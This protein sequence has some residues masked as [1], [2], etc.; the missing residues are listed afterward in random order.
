MLAA[1]LHKKILAVLLVLIV[2]LITSFLFV[3]NQAP[4]E[5]DVDFSN[6]LYP[7]ISKSSQN[8]F[9]VVFFYSSEDKN[10]VETD[11]IAGEVSPSPDMKH[12]VALTP[13]GLVI[14][15]NS[16][17]VELFVTLPTVN[18]VG[19]QAR[20]AD[21]SP[22]SQYVLYYEWIKSAQKDYYVYDLKNNTQLELTEIQDADDVVFLDDTHL[23]IQTRERNGTFSTYVRAYNFV[24]KNYSGESAVLDD[25]YN[26]INPFNNGKKWVFS[27]GN[28]DSSLKPAGSRLTLADFP[29][30]TGVTIDQGRWAEVQ[31]FSYPS[32]DG[33]FIAYYRT[34]RAPD[35]DLLGTWIYSVENKG[36]RHY[37]EAR[38]LGW[39]NDSQFISKEFGG[40]EEV[41]VINIVNDAVE[42]FQSDFY[43][44]S[45][46]NN[47]QK[48][49]LYLQGHTYQ[50]AALR[51]FDA[52]SQRSQ[53]VGFLKSPRD[54]RFYIN[55][56]VYFASQKTAIQA[57]DIY[58][59]E[60]KVLF[61][62]ADDYSE[63]VIRD[64]YVLDDD[65]F[66][67][68]CHDN[69]CQLNAL[70][71]VSGEVEKKTIFPVGLYV[72]FIKIEGDSETLYLIGRELRD[73]SS[74]N[75]GYRLDLVSG[76]LSE[77]YS[78]SCQGGPDGAET[79][80]TV[81]SG[82][83]EYN[84]LRKPLTVT[85]GAVQVTSDIT[86][87]GYPRLE[88]LMQEGETKYPIFDLSRFIACVE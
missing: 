85:C 58:T 22:N 65:V 69:E 12:A 54:T 28:T 66:F 63:G 36:A 77:V 16:N 6:M 37:A 73:Y 13:D 51:F 80:C 26:T 15:Q 60:E 44:G 75:F 71:M 32:P 57:I 19:L 68:V 46:I 40:D 33:N 59:H 70:N 72:E 31:P 24:T 81:H 18:P 86:S 25:A 74:D 53:T 10:I 67:I 45:S 43:K 42:T 47:S 30:V 78:E 9:D 38:P 3:Q 88:L 87:M 23:L 4:Q 35:Y 82:E 76:S 48:G 17:P 39:V 14:I 55:G 64:V 62:I 56:S 29:D 61:S 49:F 41:Y 52:E 8:N 79:I 34:T 1:S 2:L 11:F 84:R 83:E 21:W 5:Q 27:Q 20:F 7:F 50:N